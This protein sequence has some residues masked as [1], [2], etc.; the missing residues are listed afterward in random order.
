MQLGVGA[1]IL[2]QDHGA[3]IRPV[4]ATIHQHASIRWIQLESDSYRPVS[5]LWPRVC[6]ELFPSVVT[7]TSPK[8]AATGAA[9]GE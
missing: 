3:N 8:R 1:R 9:R 7:P 4:G 5:E 2:Y 6:S